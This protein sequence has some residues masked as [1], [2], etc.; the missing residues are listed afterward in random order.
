MSKNSKNT[1]LSNGAVFFGRESGV[2]GGGISGGPGVL[3]T[4]PWRGQ[5]WPTPLGG[6]VAWWVPLGCSRCLFAPF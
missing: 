4:M 3:H 1:S 5:A 2:A 6:V